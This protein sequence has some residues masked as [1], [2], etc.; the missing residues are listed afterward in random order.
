MRERFRR[1]ISSIAA[2]S[3]SGNVR[4]SQPLRYSK[5]KCY[6]HFSAVDP[7]DFLSSGDR[8]RLVTDQVASRRTR[9][10]RWQKKGILSQN[11]PASGE[12]GNCQGKF[13]WLGWFRNMF[14]ITGV[15]RTPPVAITRISGK[16]DRRCLVEA[17]IPDFAD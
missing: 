8:F 15:E 13:L 12:A 14:L 16:G 7:R 4:R 5:P 10:H 11:S 17:T 3:M 9:R 2:L 1:A 6:E